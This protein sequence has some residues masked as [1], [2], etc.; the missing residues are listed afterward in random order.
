MVTM[1]KAA[2]SRTMLDTVPAAS[3]VSRVRSVWVRVL[4][5]WW[6]SEASTRRWFASR[7]DVADPG[8]SGPEERELDRH[9]ETVRQ[10]W[11]VVKQESK[12]GTWD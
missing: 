1:S 8:A 2:S 3:P 7:R 10:I 11:F 12:W 4:A 6:S 5:P 9:A